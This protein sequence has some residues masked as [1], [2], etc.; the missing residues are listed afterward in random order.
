MTRDAALVGWTM[1]DSATQ[2]LLFVL[3]VISG[4]H[5]GGEVF[6]S[7]V[8]DPVWSAS[9]S[10][11]R[12]WEGTGIDPGRFYSIFS[13]LLLVLSIATLAV[14]WRAQPVVRRWLLTATLLFL[15][16]VAVTLAYFFPELMQIRTAR[17]LSIPDEE[18]AGRIRR[19]ILLDT[20]REVLVFLGF[21]FTLHALGLTYGVRSRLERSS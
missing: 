9:V 13:L 14:G 12:A 15:A 19:W 18:L 7:I 2:W 17:A 6:D 16:A 20:G 21:L 4:M 11:A 8:N 10:A 5:F 1:R 3:A